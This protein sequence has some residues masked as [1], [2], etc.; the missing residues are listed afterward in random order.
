MEAILQTPWKTHAKLIVTA[1]DGFTSHLP[2]AQE[3]DS[4]LEESFA[5]KFGSQRDGWQLIREGQI[6]YDRQKTFIPDFTFRHEDGTEVL[7]EI[8]GFWTPEYLA[9]KRE[10]LRQFR[11]HSILLAVPES[12]LREGAVLGENIVTYKTAI[13]LPPLLAAL[14]AARTAT[15]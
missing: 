6:L 9:A 4:A 10:T 12:S 8:V 11:R 7:L 5:K 1:K 15:R 13:Q 2:A 14:E 3:F